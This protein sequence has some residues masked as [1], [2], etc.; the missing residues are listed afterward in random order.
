[1]LEASEPPGDGRKAAVA[2]RRSP[3]A[4]RRAAIGEWRLVIGDRGSAIG[5]LSGNPVMLTY[6]T[7]PYLT[8][9]TLLALL[10]GAFSD[11]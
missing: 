9:L 7:L 2:D 1:M 11:F 10:T 3:I 6:L 5:L 8:I 4:G